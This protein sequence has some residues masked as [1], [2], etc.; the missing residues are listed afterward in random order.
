MI[1]N[2]LIR[3]M[4]CVGSAAGYM[5][6]ILCPPKSF[7]L[8]NYC[9][10]CFHTSRLKRR[11]KKLGAGSLLSRNCFIAGHGEIVVG[12]S[13]SIQ[14]HA[15]IETCTPESRII[16]GNRVSIG[17]YCHITA[18]KEV[19]IGDGTLTG[20]FVLIS[21][22]SH[23]HTDGRDVGKLPLEREITS[24]GKI[25]IGRNVWIGDKVSILQNVSIGD[26]AI[27]AANSVV[28]KSVPGFAVVAGNPAKVIKIMNNK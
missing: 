15:V 26:G 9:L 19:I 17:E 20:R 12:E 7:G 1:L 28:T 23:G 25:S 16:I 3:L 22:N 5:S 4:S 18:L 14:A 11:F 2:V 21:D 27:I 13:S 24:K 6:R 10:R 8:R